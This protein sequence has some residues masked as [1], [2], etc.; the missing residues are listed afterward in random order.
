[1]N[2]PNILTAIRFLI[3]PAFVYY[4]FS[5][6]RNGL[7]IATMLFVLAGLTDILDGFIARK[8]K[9]VTKLG[10]V[11]DPLADKSML[12]TVLICITVKYHIPLWV[13]I[14]VG[15]KEILMIIGAIALLNEHD[16]VIPANRFGKIST[17]A[18]YIAI[19]SMIFEL[20]QSGVLLDA[21]LILTIVA[22]IVYLNN[23][24]SIRRQH[25]FNTAKK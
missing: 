16:M 6:M 13:I 24:L 23:F 3:I 2:V 1:M 11:L 18:F 10:I 25:K 17:I 14:I 22:L 7:Q 9:L 8:Y 21:F 5:G 15:I 20:P 19:L 12:L 4:F